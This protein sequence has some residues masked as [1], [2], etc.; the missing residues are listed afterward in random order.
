MPGTVA[1]KVPGA[2]A[3]SLVNRPS[4]TASVL[5]T[6]GPVGIAPGT[7]KI[8]DSVQVA[9]AGQWVNAGTLTVAKQAE[10][11]SPNCCGGTP[12]RHND[13]LRQ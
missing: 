6:H 1:V 13:P 5:A 2:V 12:G 8:A 3:H 4:G 10:V 11:G 9:A 7:A